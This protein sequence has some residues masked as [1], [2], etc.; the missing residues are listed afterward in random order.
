MGFELSAEKS[1]CSYVSLR[2][3]HCNHIFDTF[4]MVVILLVFML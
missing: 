2:Y 4:Y 3:V 1:E